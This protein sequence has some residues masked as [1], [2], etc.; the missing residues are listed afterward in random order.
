MPIAQLSDARIHYTVDGDEHAPPLLLS[1][2]LGTSLDM[3]Q[4]Q[5][6]A[7]ASRF[8]VVRYDS[9]GHGQSQVTPGPYTIE[10]LATD[11]LHVLDALSIPRAH[12]CGLSMGGMVGMWIGIHAPQR[13]DRLVLAN[14]AAKIGTAEMWN[15]RIEAVRN[16]GMQAI[17]SAVLA[18]FLTSAMIEAPTPMVAEIR[19]TLEEMS[20][21]G[22]IASCAA[23]RDMDQRHLLGRIHAPTLVIAGLEDLSTPPDEGRYVAD[24][25]PRARFVELQAT[26]L[27]NV[28]AAPAFTQALMQFLTA[29]TE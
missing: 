2:S 16:G 23:V 1:N 13:V 29:R 26:H 21:D 27:S 22:Y 3:W 10:Q 12:F 17:A 28:Q 5:M 9:R 25:I 14:T 7:L 15:A 4:P 20:P 19:K 8:R 11:A 18:R 6:A 24:H